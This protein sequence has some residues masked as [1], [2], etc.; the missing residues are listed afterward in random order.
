[1]A[2]AAAAAGTMFITIAGPAL[3]YLYQNKQTE[4]KHEESKQVNTTIENLKE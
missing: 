4:V 2:L 1:V 3:I